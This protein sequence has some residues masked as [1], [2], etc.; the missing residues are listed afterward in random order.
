MVIL[1]PLSFLPGRRAA[2]SPST[3]STDSLVEST[4]QF[5]VTLLSGLGDSGQIYGVA[6]DGIAIGTILDNDTVASVPVVSVSDVTVVEGD[7]DIDGATQNA[8]LTISLDQTAQQDVTVSLATS[9]GTATD[10]GHG[11]SGF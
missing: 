5:T 9:A 1:A 2:S 8:T 11:W 7:P 3:F 10:N 6:G 4:E